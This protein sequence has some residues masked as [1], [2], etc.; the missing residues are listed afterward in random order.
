MFIFLVFREKKKRRCPTILSLLGC[1]REVEAEVEVEA[2]SQQ[3]KRKR[4]MLSKRKRRK[5]FLLR[6]G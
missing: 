1:K 2:E 4:R 6:L 3:P 5:L